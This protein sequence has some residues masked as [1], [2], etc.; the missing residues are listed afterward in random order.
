MIDGQSLGFLRLFCVVFKDY[1]DFNY[2]QWRDR[3]TKVNELLDKESALLNFEH[4]SEMN[5]FCWNSLSTNLSNKIGLKVTCVPVKPK[6][7]ELF[8]A[9]LFA[10]TPIAIWTRR[11]LAINCDCVNVLDQFLTGKLLSN[12]CESIRMLRQQ[13]DAD[14]E[15]HFGSHLAVLWEDPYRLTPDVMVE[16]EQVGK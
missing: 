7:E 10:A 1:L 12:L 5:N 4:L 14:T 3:W 8:R 6:L 9:I 2:S 11:D 16:L 15:E 13:A